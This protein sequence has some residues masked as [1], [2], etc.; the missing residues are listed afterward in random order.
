MTPTKN[1][2]TSRVLRG[3]SWNNVEPSW[4]RA[5]SRGTFV[6]AGRYDSIGFRTALPVRQPR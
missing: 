6:P 3:G 1:D 2:T 5:A 4:V